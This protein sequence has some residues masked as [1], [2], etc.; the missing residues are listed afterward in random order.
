M[1]PSL[2]NEGY[3]STDEDVH[4]SSLLPPLHVCSFPWLSFLCCVLSAVPWPQLQRRPA[5]LPEPDEA[6]QPSAAHHQLCEGRSEVIGQ[7]DSGECQRPH[8]GSKE[9]HGSCSA[10]SQNVLHCIKSSESWSFISSKALGSLY[11]QLS[12]TLA[13]TQMLLLTLRT[14]VRMYMQVRYVRAWFVQVQVC[15]QTLYILYV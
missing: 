14:Y 6:L 5:G 7:G 13:C 2:A 1:L 12:L 3:Q 10:D 8:H 4:S 11:L 9:P 15:M